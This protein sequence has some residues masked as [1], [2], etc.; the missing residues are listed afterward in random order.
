MS[1]FIFKIVEPNGSTQFAVVPATNP[2]SAFQ[3]VS[4]CEPYEGSR[5]HHAT[6]D[7]LRDNYAVAYLTTERY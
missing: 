7:D 5:I 2:H 3:M 1:L 4:A 6:D